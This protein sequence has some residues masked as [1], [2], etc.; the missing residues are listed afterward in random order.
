MTA[1]SVV[2]D[3]RGIRGV[4]LSSAALVHAA[5]P[6]TLALGDVAAWVAPSAPAPLPASEF[7]V[8]YHGADKMEVFGR[9][10]LMYRGRMPVLLAATGGR[11]IES[12]WPLYSAWRV[13]TLVL[14][15]SG[16]EEIEFRYENKKKGN[17]WH[18][19]HTF[20]GILPNMERRYQETESNAVREEPGKYQSVQSCQSCG[21]T[22]LNE[23]ARNVFVQDRSL[24]AINGMSV[25]DALEFMAALNLKGWRGEVAGIR[26][27]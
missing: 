7:S 10:P 20:E 9:N 6:L 26:Q 25:T 19:K 15:G 14:H 21:G 23:A 18:W 16:E 13:P 2:R 17:K 24:P 27:K 22:R 1:S 12:N 4:V 8:L 5:S 3:Q 11:L